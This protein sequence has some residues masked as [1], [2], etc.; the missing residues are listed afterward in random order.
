MQPAG[1]MPPVGGV[2][3]FSESRGKSGDIAEMIF[4]EL[5]LF[6]RLARTG[7]SVKPITRHIQVSL[8]CRARDAG[9]RFLAFNIKPETAIFNTYSIIPGMG[10]KLSQ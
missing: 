5:P 6:R 3:W 9:I 1:I 2:E 8:A 4:Q 10:Q 7:M